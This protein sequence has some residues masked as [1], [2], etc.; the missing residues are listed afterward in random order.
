MME[1]QGAIG[2]AQLAKLDGMISS[3]KVNKAF[4][5]GEIS[6]IP[7]VGFRK[8]LD[9]EGDSATFIAFMMADEQQAS[10]VAALLAENGAAPIRWGENTWHFYPSWEHFHGEKTLCKNGWPFKAHG[11][12]RFIYSPDLLPVSAEIMGR[13]LCYP[14]PV[15]LA[16]ADGEKLQKAIEAVRAKL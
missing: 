4:M 9:E 6:K 1:L 2:L 5:K 13:T 14:V 8:I 11:K 7:G 15:K 3:Q 16:E 12:R 10:D